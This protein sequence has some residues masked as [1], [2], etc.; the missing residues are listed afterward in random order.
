MDDGAVF[1]VARWLTARCGNVI[2][3]SYAKLLI[4]ILLVFH[5]VWII[6]PFPAH[7]ALRN[8]FLSSITRP[9]AI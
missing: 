1:L 7:A 5:P 9:E 8:S 3:I 2:E 6:Y 4:D